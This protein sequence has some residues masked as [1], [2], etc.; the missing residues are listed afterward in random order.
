[1]IGGIK[2]QMGPRTKNQYYS[3]KI[4]ISLSLDT[5]QNDDVETRDGEEG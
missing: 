4:K 1:M 5:L 2:R 3:K